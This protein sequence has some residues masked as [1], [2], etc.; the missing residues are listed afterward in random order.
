MKHLIPLLILSLAMACSPQSE[1]QNFDKEAVA[2]DINR[3]FDAYHEALNTEGILAEF[4]YL[5]TS[6]DFF[7][8]PPG[9]SSALTYDSIKTI[10]TQNDILLDSVHFEWESLK[11]NP[12]E[13]NRSK[14][15]PM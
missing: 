7:W 11:V 3:M 15:K 9:Y 1:S 13:I 14:K 6:E 2:A 10:I 12:M 4:D 5:D 8:V